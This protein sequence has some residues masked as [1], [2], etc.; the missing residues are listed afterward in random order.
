M[1]DRISLTLAKLRL[2]IGAVAWLLSTRWR[3]ALLALLIAVLFFE[4]VYWFFN[5]PVLSTI[6]FSGNVSLIE[7]LQVLSSPV[8]SI[9][10]ASGGLLLTFMLL[11]ALVQG[12][13]L[14]SLIYV[15][16]QQRK[17]DDKLVSGSSFATLFAIIGLGC[18]ACGTSLITPVVALFI[19]GSAVT[20]S[21][22]ITLVATP[23]ALGIGLYGLYA[24][25]LKLA[26]VRA[27]ESAKNPTNA[28]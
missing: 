17:V 19:S 7:K 24:V 5:F 20:V 21:Q 4:L 23:L 22:R 13:L 14:A 18:P 9:G 8:Q 2:S 12:I 28:T 11:L 3:Y 16:R 6:V 1:K 15:V 10:A 25:G 27:K 26:N